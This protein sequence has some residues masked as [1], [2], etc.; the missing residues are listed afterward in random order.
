MTDRQYFIKDFRDR[1]KDPDYDRVF[2]SYK[3]GL[4]TLHEVLEC[5]YDIELEKIKKQFKEA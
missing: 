2:L 5:L 3:R 4:I 1:Y